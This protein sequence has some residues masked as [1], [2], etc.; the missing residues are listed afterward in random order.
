MKMVDWIKSV[1]DLFKINF[2]D[3]LTHKGNISHEEAVEKAESEYEKYKII[4]DI[5]D[6]TLDDVD[7]IS[8]IKIDRRKPS[9]ER[10]LEFITK[11]KNPYIFKINGKL[12]RI[13]FADTDKTAEDCLTNV[14]KNLYK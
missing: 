11:V 1:E 3:N 7:E 9:N 13:S 4:Q 10:L 5:E 12:V 6:V 8:S 14:L 2:Y